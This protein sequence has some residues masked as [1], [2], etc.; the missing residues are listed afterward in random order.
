M[1]S[2]IIPIFIVAFLGYI[3]MM[4]NAPA[5]EVKNVL[6]T[7]LVKD[8]KCES[9]GFNFCLAEADLKFK[10]AGIIKKEM[11]YDNKYTREELITILKGGDLIENKN[12]AIYRRFQNYL[13][14]FIYL[15]FLPVLYIFLTRN[16]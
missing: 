7:E 12:Y 14:V 15:L 10:E 4:L 16:K 3:Y 1:R 2:K 9:K 5:K 6:K 11:L 13:E 8:L